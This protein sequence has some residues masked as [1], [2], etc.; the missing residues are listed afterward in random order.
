MCNN[1]GKR[2]DP[3]VTNLIL[4]SN[5]HRGLGGVGGV[6]EE[7]QIQ[8]LYHAIYELPLFMVFCYQDDNVHIVYSY[9][10]GISTMVLFLQL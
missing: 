6:G 1:V 3:G 5:I 9:L 7:R 2:V 4:S 10:A 8:N